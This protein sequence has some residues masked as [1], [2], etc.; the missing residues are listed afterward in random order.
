MKR[1]SIAEATLDKQIEA[2]DVRLETLRESITNL[3]IEFSTTQKIRDRLAIESHNLFEAR[4]IAS[5]SR[6]P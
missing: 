5:E 6:K 4:R 2:L 3:Q 1:K